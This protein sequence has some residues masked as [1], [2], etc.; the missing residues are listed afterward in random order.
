MDMLTEIKDQSERLVDRALLR[1]AEPASSVVRL[2][3]V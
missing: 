3:A 2:I 1:D